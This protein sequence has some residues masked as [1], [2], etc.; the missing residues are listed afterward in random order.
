M[1]FVCWFYIRSCWFHRQSKRWSWTRSNY[2]PIFKSKMADQSQS[3]PS[4]SPDCGGSY[5]SRNSLTFNSNN[6]QYHAITCKLLQERR[7][8]DTLSQTQ[9][10]HCWMWCVMM[11]SPSQFYIM[12]YISSRSFC[13]LLLTKKMTHVLT[14]S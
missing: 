8:S 6:M 13:H 10:M 4:S 14:S 2:F 9:T 11:L 7:I 12:F 1:H 3:P 5:K